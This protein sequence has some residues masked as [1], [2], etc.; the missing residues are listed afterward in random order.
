M[1]VVHPLPRH[2]Q[3]LSLYTMVM[4]Y[5]QLSWLPDWEQRY[6]TGTENNDKSILFLSR[7]HTIT[8][9]CHA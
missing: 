4:V 5:Q 3:T 7:R 8:T 9:I 1:F 6:D 2:R